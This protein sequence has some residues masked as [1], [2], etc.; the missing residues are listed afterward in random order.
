VII[1]EKSVSTSNLN[2]ASSDRYRTFDK[3]GAERRWVDDNPSMGSVF[4][5]QVAEKTAFVAE[6]APFMK[7]KE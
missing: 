5:K 4:V 3:A 6:K 2:I 1:T 7:P